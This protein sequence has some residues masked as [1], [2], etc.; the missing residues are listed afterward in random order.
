MRNYLTLTTAI[1]LAACSPQLSGDFDTENTIRI[2]E[3]LAADD[4]EGRRTGSPGA[5][6]AQAFLRDEIAALNIFDKVYDDTFITKP[7]KNKDGVIPENAPTY[8][9]INIHGLIDI[10]DEDKGPLL[11]IT[12]HY[13]HL[14]IRG[15]KIFNGADDNASGSA[16]LF[17]IA[18][19]FAKTPPENDILFIWFD[20][21]EMGLQ[22]ARHYVLS[23]SYGDR[24]VFNLNLYMISQ[25][26]TNEIYASGTYHNPAVKPLVRRAAERSPINVLFGHDRPEDGPNDW[27]LQ[28]DHGPF[29]LA[30][31][32]YLYFG[33]AD[34]PFYHRATDIFETTPQEFYKKSLQLIV[35]TAHVLD[36]NLETIARPV[37]N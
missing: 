5:A 4:M 18:Q 31:L 25:S 7:R 21:E 30:G 9:A 2:M 1:L 32:P 20:A 35:D 24:P 11:V 13:D 28:S 14:G 26:K 27:T 6:K 16:A 8:E 33:V 34:H 37:Q 23:G 29:H 36:E 17:A 22:G 3:T 19:S 12:A 15:D 10:D